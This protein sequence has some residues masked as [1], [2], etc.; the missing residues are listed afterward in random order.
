MEPS[1]RRRPPL[2]GT[3]TE[4]LRGFLDEQRDTL[5]WKAGGLDHGAMNRALAPSTLTIAGL[6]KHLAF[7]ESFWFAEVFAG[8][9]LMPPFDT[10]DWDADWDW[11]FTTAPDDSPET[12]F[13]LY[14]QARDAS[15]VILD[16]ALSTGGLDQRA[17]VKR[18]KHPEPV[19]LGWILV[20]LIEEYARHNG[21]LDLIRES[22]DGLTG[23]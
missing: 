2:S 10:A 21:H 9:T 8:G 6:L 17:A 11:E 18:D 1:E 13:A 4:L 16:R 7:V 19:S 12:L 22:I 15:D 23:A 5:L 3:P 14:A 20:H